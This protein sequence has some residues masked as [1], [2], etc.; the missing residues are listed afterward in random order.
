MKAVHEPF[1]QNEAIGP[2]DRKK[3]LRLC[4]LQGQG[5]FTQDVLPG[6]QCLLHGS[7]VIRAQV[8][9]VNCVDPGIGQEC[10]V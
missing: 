2:G 5:L 10:L 7:S 4:A 6:A 1:E 9:D 8:G 3:I